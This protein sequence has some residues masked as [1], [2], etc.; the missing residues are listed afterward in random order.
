M[1]SVV[2]GKIVYCV[3][4]DCE[5]DIVGL[6]NCFSVI[7][8]K[9]NNLYYTWCDID[10]KYFDE[11][12]IVVFETIEQGFAN[13]A[14]EFRQLANDALFEKNGDKIKIAYGKILNICKNLAIKGEC[15]AKI[16]TLRVKELENSFIVN[17]VASLLRDEKFEVR[18]ICWENGDTFEYMEIYW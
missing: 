16:N 6:S 1:D 9:E 15:V 14:E 10:Q 4:E 18:I 13:K 2:T 5:G 11:G 17:E 7:Y 3:V 12:S 8:D